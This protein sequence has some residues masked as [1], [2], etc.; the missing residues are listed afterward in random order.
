MDAVVTVSSGHLTLVARSQQGDQEALRSL[1]DVF[2]DRVY[3]IALC[4]LDGNE[5]AAADVTQ[6]VFITLMTRIGQF[7]GDAE[8]TTWLYRIVINA[9]RD[10]QRKRRRF[11]FFSERPAIV[12]VPDSRDLHREAERDALGAEVRNAIAR[13]PR[14]VRSAVVLKY[15]EGMSYEEIARVL[16]C[17]KGT[18][19]SRLNRAHKTLARTLEHL[20]ERGDV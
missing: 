16:N 15:F 5:A 12:D 17:S 8:F 7:R 9:C 19:A 3:S 18:V 1:F 20:R 14:K 6:R 2:G 4:T 11:V 10:E 13:L